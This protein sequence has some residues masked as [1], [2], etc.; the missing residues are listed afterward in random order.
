MPERQRAYHG[1]KT[2]TI[3]EGKIGKR[4]KVK[5]RDQFGFVHDVPAKEL[6][7][8]DDNEPHAVLR[9]GTNED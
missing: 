7:A 3:L 8:I 5:I 4:G 1:D 2:V 9:Y 6:R